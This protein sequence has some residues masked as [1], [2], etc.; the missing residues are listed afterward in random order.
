M[1]DNSSE[2]FKFEISLSVLNHLGRN[3]YRNFIT[4]LGEAISNSWD[5]EAKNV[6]IDIDQ[7]KNSFTVK[8]DG[9]GMNADDFQHKFLRIGYSKRKDGDTNSEKM[10]RPFIGAKGI[11]KLALLSCAES[12]A[13]ISKTENSDYVGGVIVNS[14]LDHAIEDELLPEQY[15]L[16]DFNLDDVTHLTGGHSKGTILL[17]NDLKDNMRNTIPYIKSLIAL[18]YRFSLVDEEFNIIVNGEVVS[19]SDLQSL[20]DSTEFLWIINSLQDPF[21]ETFAGLKADIREI[22]SKLSIKGFIASV[23][24]PS[25]LK[26]RG[27]EERVGIDLFVNGRL[28]ERDLLK[29]V[30][31]ARIPES[32]LYGQIH[33][34]ELDGDGVDRFTSSREGVLEGDHKFQSLL[35]E[36]KYRIMPGILDEWDELRLNRGDDG[37]DENRRKSPKQRK[38]RSLYK[39]SKDEYSSDGDTKDKVD[40]WLDKLF[41]D[42]EYNVISYTDCFIS[43]NLIREFIRDQKVPLTTPAENEIATWKDREKKRKDEANISFVIREGDDGLSYLG[44]DFLAKSV[45]SHLATADNASLVKDAVEFKPMRNAV[46]HTGLLSENAKSKLSLVRE[47]IR[48]RLKKLLH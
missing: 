38:A 19:F 1:T 39:L 45:E 25:H 20:S 5:A 44:M 30:P 9:N 8:D 10:G 41:D 14:A 47:N 2:N 22:H 13:V 35:D 26:V 16:E 3:L 7:Q 46:G 17:F 31:T 27:T 23:A 29:H 48:G 15:E 37:D 32:Y 24:K 43:E 33:F 36:L 18:Y 4:V 21:L 42:A 11:G 40:I 34:D 6:Y 12:I 28:R